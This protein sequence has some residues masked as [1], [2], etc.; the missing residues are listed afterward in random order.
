MNDTETAALLAAATGGC[1]PA[2]S[3][4]LMLDVTDTLGLSGEPEHEADE[5]MRAAA[6]LQ[7][8]AAAAPRDALEAMLAAQMAAAHG[9]A[10][11]AMRRA[12]ECTNYPRI[13][14][15]Y[16]RQAARLMGLFMRQMETLERRRAAA[17]RAEAATE[18]QAT[19]LRSST[20]Q[21]KPP[22]RLKRPRGRR[23]GA[24]TPPPRNGHRINGTGPPFAQ[25]ASK[26]RPPP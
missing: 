5:A 18:A 12:A 4:R 22:H 25:Q 11:R 9:A 7:M 3:Q 19:A 8:M 2:L 15:L 14:A 17:A 10:M 6:A 21:T 26:G 13:E 23:N 24:A 1:A 20:K 16:A